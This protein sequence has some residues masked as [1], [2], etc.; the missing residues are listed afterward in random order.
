[1]TNNH[2]HHSRAATSHGVESGGNHHATVTPTTTTIDI[3]TSGN[4]NADDT[5][6]S[7][8]RVLDLCSKFMASV[9]STCDRAS[10]RKD[11]K[12]LILTNQMPA[13]E[14]NDINLNDTHSSS[15]SSSNSPSSGGGHVVSSINQNTNNSIL[16]IALPAGVTAITTSS[17][18]S[19]SSRSPSQNGGGRNRSDSVNGG[20]ASGSTSGSSGSGS[21]VESVNHAGPNAQRTN[22]FSSSTGSA[23]QGAM[24]QNT[25][26]GIPPCIPPNAETFEF[27]V[28]KTL[29]YSLN[30]VV[31]HHAPIHT[32]ASSTNQPAAD[33]Y[34]SVQRRLKSVLDGCIVNDTTDIM[35]LTKNFTRIQL[36]QTA[37][38]MF[39]T[40]RETL[41]H[42]EIYPYL[43]TNPKLA[44]ACIN[45][46]NYLFGKRVHVGEARLFLSNVKV[47]LQQTRNARYLNVNHY[48]GAAREHMEKIK[49]TTAALMGTYYGTKMIMEMNN[50]Y[51]DFSTYEGLRRLVDLSIRAYENVSI[52]MKYQ[53]TPNGFQRVRNLLKVLDTEP[54]GIDRL[55]KFVSVCKD[56]LS[57]NN[58]IPH[59]ERKPNSVTFYRLSA[60][61]FQLYIANIESLRTT[62]DQE[63]IASINRL[64][65]NIANQ[66]AKYCFEN[67][68]IFLIGGGVYIELY[69]HA[70]RTHAARVRA[71]LGDMNAS[72]AELRDILSYLQA[73]IQTLDALYEKYETGEFAQMSKEL[74]M[75]A[76]SIS[77][78]IMMLKELAKNNAT[79]TSYSD[80]GSMGSTNVEDITTSYPYSQQTTSSHPDIQQLYTVPA[81]SSSLMLTQ[82]PHMQFLSQEQQQQ[83]QR[84]NVTL[85]YSPEQGHIVDPGSQT[86]FQSGNLFHFIPNFETLET[87][88]S[89]SN[90][91]QELFPT[92]GETHMDHYLLE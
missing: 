46:V 26:T 60:L 9:N 50:D 68:Q 55:N 77:P 2:Q 36:R 82:Q 28:N 51:K 78:Q 75:L 74:K 91:L 57:D 59:E 14:D 18:S 48:S 1:M 12:H 53:E 6:V 11:L 33:F 54:E 37:D 23:Q 30:A 86:V 72:H 3:N 64:K 87:I 27:R 66:I 85:P 90:Q 17:S 19:S 22:P 92:E 43:A 34:Q 62:Y 10:A 88:L 84:T 5:V 45:I 39:R 89:N 4:G 73:E 24:M 42:P 15:T 20:G 35:E 61:G 44:H 67:L 8:D 38:D 16:K 52:A 69:L 49:E 80:S 41:L 65:L 58:W 47:F 21:G 83:Q 40:A 29:F 56:L 81:A 79:T 13:A 31:L 70:C 63:T 25:T 7:L 32:S 71:L 76:Q